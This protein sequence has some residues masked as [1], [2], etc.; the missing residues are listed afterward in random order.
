MRMMLKM[1]HAA[2]VIQVQQ[3]WEALKVNISISMTNRMANKNLVSPEYE[4]IY[5]IINCFFLG[6][7]LLITSQ[8]RPRCVN[9]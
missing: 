9:L 3:T 2:N 5:Q 8:S 6:I 4:T 1:C 7:R